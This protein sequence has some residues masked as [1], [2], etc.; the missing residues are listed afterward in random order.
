MPPTSPLASAALALEAALVAAGV[1]LLWRHGL[2]RA[3]R[4]A[5]A[6]LCPW[7]ATTPDFLAFVVC[8]L[9]STFVVA[10][11]GGALAGFAGFTGPARTIANGAAAQLGM[12][13]GVVLH[14]RL[15]ESRRPEP[16][17]PARHLLRTGFA[18]FLLSLPP[19]LAVAHAADFLLRRLGLPAER[20]DL[21]RLLGELDSP[22]LLAAM[23]LLAI[24]V[25]PLTEELVF[26]RG[27]FRYLRTR[28]PRWAALLAP[29]AGF[30][31]LHVNW[32]TLEG[33]VSAPPLVLLAVVFSLAYERT[34]HVG[35]VVVAHACFN[36]NTLIVVF[37]GLGPGTP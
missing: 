10:A 30:A 21:I 20:Q 7:E 1:V 17:P 35:T 13:A 31:A 11:L 15:F 2:S 8:V 4:S 6:R 9:G 27:V 32:H 34:G 24:G 26:R 12:L 28:W 19:L 25:A 29:A 5:P 36:L 37:A 3:A 22:A 23:V 18:T 14:H 16:P 33:L